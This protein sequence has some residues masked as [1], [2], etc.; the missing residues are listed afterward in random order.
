MENVTRKVEQLKITFEPFTGL[1][2][3]QVPESIMLGVSPQRVITF[4]LLSL[5]LVITEVGSGPQ[6][7]QLVMTIPS[8]SL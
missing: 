1:Y 7:R 8:F 4:Q 5:T 3:L 6:G 2:Q